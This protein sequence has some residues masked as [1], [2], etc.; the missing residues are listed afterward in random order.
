MPVLV[1]FNDGLVVMVRFVLSA[2]T[3]ATPVAAAVT[4]TK[5]QRR[6]PN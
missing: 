5:T 3:V 1:V 6:L 4:V 2:M